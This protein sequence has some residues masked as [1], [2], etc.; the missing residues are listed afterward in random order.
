M[1][2]LRAKL[3]PN[4]VSISKV[5]SMNDGV[6]AAVAGVTVVRQR[7]RGKD[8]IVFITISDESGNLQLIVWPTVYDKFRLALSNSIVLV[9]GMISKRDRT[10]NLIV[11][12]VEQIS[13]YNMLNVSH[14]WY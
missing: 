3:K 10:T 2:F 14:D 11:S 1:E 7:P 9:H 13:H 4:I 5:Y 8:G 6:S 12:H